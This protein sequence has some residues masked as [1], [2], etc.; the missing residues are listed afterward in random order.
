[1]MG[2]MKTERERK[3]KR[4]RSHDNVQSWM[5]APLEVY[6][7]KH[8]SMGH[9]VSV[10]AQE[11]GSNVLFRCNTCDAGCETMESLISETKLD[12]LE[13]ADCGSGGPVH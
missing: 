5:L 11:D 6:Y 8:L 13:T 1:M 3:I 2:R 4:M 9:H 10:H 7:L 12:V